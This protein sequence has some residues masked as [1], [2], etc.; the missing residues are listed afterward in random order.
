[1]TDMI[2]QVVSCDDSPAIARATAILRSGN[3]VAAATETVYGLA[4]DATNDEAVKKIYQVKG[5]PSNNPLI[6]HVL[7]ISMAE[8][9]VEV[10][11]TAKLLMEKFWPG[12]LTLVLPQRTPTQIAPTVSA[13]LSTLAV[14]CP[15]HPAMRSLIKGSGL[16]LAAPSANP[17]GKISPTTA[18]HVRSGLDGKIEMIIDGGAT[19]L[20][21]ESTIISIDQND[22]IRLLRPGTITSDEIADASNKDILDNNSN[23]ITA[24]GQLESHYAPDALIRLNAKTALAGEY[25]IG[26]GEVKGNFN[27]SETG[28]LSEAAK[29]LFTAIGKADQSADKIA[30]APIPLTG[31]GLAIND[32]IKRAAAPRPQTDTDTDHHLNSN[33]NE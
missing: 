15:N 25:H 17:S 20:G 1:M 22:V 13:G 23:H 29:K 10:S 19:D 33:G 28:D 9:L 2:T 24:P 12:P 32:R 27:L 14:R 4:A 21:I 26:F 5:R 7:D 6:C 18:E 3:L 30:I 16:P 31:I 11:E 8:S